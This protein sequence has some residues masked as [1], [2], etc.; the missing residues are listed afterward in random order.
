[1]T[2]LHYELFVIDRFKRRKA[3]HIQSISLIYEAA[4]ADTSAAEL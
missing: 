3:T 1:M 4:S 2:H